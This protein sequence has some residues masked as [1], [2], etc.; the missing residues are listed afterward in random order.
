MGATSFK[1]LER[2]YFQY[3]TMG[4]RYKW[5]LLYKVQENVQSLIGLPFIRE[6]GLLQQALSV[7]ECVECCCLPEVANDFKMCLTV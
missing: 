5:P 2:R 7:K 4:L 3:V 1:L 6:L